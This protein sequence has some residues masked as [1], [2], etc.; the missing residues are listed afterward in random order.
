MSDLVRKARL[1]DLDAIVD[2]L[3]Q[4]TPMKEGSVFNRDK[5]EIIFRK[6]LENENYCL[7]VFEDD[8]EVLGT[9]LLL[10]QMNISQGGRPYAHI[11]NVV[12]DKDCRGK[13]AGKKMMDYLIGRARGLN[14]YKVLLNCGKDNIPF[15]EKC[16]FFDSGEVEMRLVG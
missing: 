5:V 14:C 6:I 8:G 1:D 16:G 2:L 9:A 4:L 12:V 10:V 3:E 13:G 15:Y 11:E 7:C